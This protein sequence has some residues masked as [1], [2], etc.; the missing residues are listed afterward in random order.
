MINF[1]LFPFKNTL[2]MKTA[3]YPKNETAPTYKK[4]KPQKPNI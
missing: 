3:K 1:A 2:K 4:I